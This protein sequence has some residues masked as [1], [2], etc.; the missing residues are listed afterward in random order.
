MFTTKSG[1][2]LHSKIER[3]FTGI[4]SVQEKT[5]STVNDKQFSHII[6]HKYKWGDVIKIQ[7]Q[8]LSM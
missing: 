2:F 5:A 7:Q 6:R 3:E 1:K 8:T 4:T